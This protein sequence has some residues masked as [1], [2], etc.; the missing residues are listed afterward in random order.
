MLLDKQV[1][2]CGGL[3]NINCYLYDILTNTWRLYSNTSTMYDYTGVVHQ[4]KVYLP[5]Y[6]T[7]DVFD[8]P[9]KVWS[10]WPVSPTKHLG[11][12]YVSWKNYIIKFGGPDSDSIGQIWRFDPA[13]N[14]WTKLNTT[15][16][17]YLYC[18]GCTV[19]PNENVLI[20]GCAWSGDCFYN[21]VEYNVTG[22]SWSI[23][24]KGPTHLYNSSPLLLG[25]RVFIRP[26]SYGN[27][28][29][30]Y[31]YENKTVMPVSQT[32]DSRNNKIPCVAVPAS[33]FVN[34]PG[35]CI[36]IN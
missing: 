8:P 21:I 18:V 6:V 16:P 29:L 20:T 13:T 4:G 5:N 17:S 33:W 27:T 11:S 23:V 30:E 35:V 36:G 26:G 34:F 24:I 28:V 14:A 3:N 9:T 12:C 31:F 25:K 32:L 2:A 22:N 19:L 15:V 7:S 10:T 1:L